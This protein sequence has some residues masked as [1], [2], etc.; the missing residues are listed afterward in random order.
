M[1]T[2]AGRDGDSSGTDP[3]MP[4]L[5]PV[6]PKP[7]AQVKPPTKSKP[8]LQAMQLLRNRRARGRGRGVLKAKTSKTPKPTSVA[9][10]LPFFAGTSNAMPVAAPQTIE[11]GRRADDLAAALD[12]ITPTLNSEPRTSVEMDEAPKK[13]GHC[14]DRALEEIEVS[15]EA[16]AKAAASLNDE[17]LDSEA[18]ES[19]GDL[20]DDEENDSS[21]KQK[22]T[23][24]GLRL[25]DLPPGAPAAASASE[26]VLTAMSAAEGGAPPVPGGSSFGPRFQNLSQPE[27]FAARS[28]WQLHSLA[29]TQTTS[30]EENRKAAA[31]LFTILR[32]RR[33]AKQ[34]KEAKAHEDQ[35]A[36]VPRSSR[37][38]FRR[39]TRDAAAAPTP[40]ARPDAFST[41]G[42]RILEECVAGSGHKVSGRRK[43]DAEDVPED[44]PAAVSAAKRRKAAVCVAQDA[45]D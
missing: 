2:G 30:S 42:V 22:P 16:K 5:I 20:D 24:A 4:L 33:E 35:Q 3:D 36:E 17:L 8:M 44:V 38:L 39:P 26:E 37:P 13:P 7:V 15:K 29:G 41:P 31:D 1:D 32:Q 12:K 11:F 25:Q 21:V 40:A 14:F 19:D 6:S 28:K 45:D 34:D 9:R 43:A 10:S 27:L 23:L 18:S